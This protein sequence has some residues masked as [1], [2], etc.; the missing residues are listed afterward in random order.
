M[1]FLLKK[2]SCL[3]ALDQAKETCGSQ[4]NT[5]Y[6][7]FEFAGDR[8]SITAV[9]SF[10]QQVVEV[11]VDELE[12]S[13]GESFVIDGRAF[14]DFIRQMPDDEVSVE[15]SDLKLKISTTAGRKVKYSLNTEDPRVFAPIIFSPSK[16]KVTLSPGTLATALKAT[17]HSAHKEANYRPYTS[18]RTT[19]REGTVMCEATDYTRIAVYAA[20]APEAGKGA[21]EI[22]L[23]RD[24]AQV[25]SNILHRGSPQE[26]TLNPSGR[27]IILEWPG[28]MFVSTTEFET[29]KAFNPLSEYFVDPSAQVKVSRDGFLGALR[30]CA[31]L[32]PDAAITVTLLK[33]GGGVQLL[34]QES[35][36]G[37]GTDVVPVITDE[38]EKLTNPEVV[39][40]VSLRAL[41]KAV[42]SCE[43]PFIKLYTQLVAGQAIGIVVE[44]GNENLRNLVLPVAEI[45]TETRS[46]EEDVETSDEEE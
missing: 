39:S 6:V 20:E 13:D 2:S 36:R 45:A 38:D 35:D 21:F 28:T 22:L 29:P 26:M 31:F 19:L 18:V 8:L 15:L 30:L 7:K 5:K 44:D 41:V 14:I 43:E 17:F 10:A 37:T 23:P 11:P 4:G 16:S 24:N 33:N 3:P 25:L 40:K 34:A 1:K 46:N 27:H 32:D 12:A 9:N 42:E